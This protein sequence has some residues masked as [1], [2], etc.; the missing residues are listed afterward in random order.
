MIASKIDDEAKKVKEEE[1][2]KRVASV[3]PFQAVKTKIFNVKNVRP[4]RKIS[5]QFGDYCFQEQK[6]VNLNPIK[7]NIRGD[8]SEKK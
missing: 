8:S 1:N 3:S 2:K 5:D 7:V 4:S 6:K